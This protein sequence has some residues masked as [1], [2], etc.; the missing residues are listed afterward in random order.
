LKS[1]ALAVV[2][3]QSGCFVP[4]SELRLCPF[5]NIITRL[6]GKDNMHGGQGTFAVE[7]SE[8][9][10]ILSLATP[11]SLVLGDEI[12]HG[13]E[14]PSAISIVAASIKDMVALNMNFLFATH[15]HALAAMPGVTDLPTVQFKHFH[16]ETRIRA[17]GDT[18]IIYNRKLQPGS[19]PATYGIEVAA[20]QGIP[21][22]VIKEAH[23]IRRELCGE[24]TT[25]VDTRTSHYNASVILDRCGVPGCKEKATETHHIRF[26]CDAD[27]SGVIDDRF[28]KNSGFNLVGLC[29]PHHAD[30]TYNRLIIS[31]WALRLDGTRILMV[32]QPA[33]Q[34]PPQATSTAAKYARKKK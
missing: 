21:E 10:T 14:Y 13:T 4:A 17:N 15:L 29:S 8:L 6:S 32:E 30:V 16:V 27:E 31:G 25:I 3:A 34:Q 33:V 18:E 7:M 9:T 12:C 5:S 23:R 1:V 22:R 26:Q 20:A 2:M 11:Q 28:H 19:G 24:A